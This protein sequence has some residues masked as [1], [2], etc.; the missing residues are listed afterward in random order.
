MASSQQSKMLPVFIM[1]VASYYALTHL[2][3]G[4]VILE[5]SVINWP[6]ALV[7]VW[8]LICSFVF[9]S[10]LFAMIGNGFERA[11]AST[12]RQN[13]GKAS[14]ANWWSLRK[15]ILRNKWGPY[16]GVYAS[17]FLNRG[18]PIFAD[19]SSNVVTFGTTGAG[20][21]VGVVIPTC[22]AIRDSKLLPDFKSNNSCMLKPALEARGWWY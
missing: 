11:A 5:G 6:A 7:T 1:A 13:K 16:W 10:G 12:P 18:K 22:L 20:K 8:C 15:D 3:L 21:G 4:P 9:V 17:G 19:Y 2:S 14:W